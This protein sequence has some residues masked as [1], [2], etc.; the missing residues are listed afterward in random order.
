MTGSLL[1][2]AVQLKVSDV[3]T[4]EQRLVAV[5]RH[6]AD[7]AAAGADLVVLPEMWFQGYFA[8]DSYVD[9]AEPI[10]GPLATAL[11][12]L[13]AEHGVNLLAGSFAERADT[14]IHNTTL[15]FDREGARRAAYR[16][17]H[18]YGYG[19]KEQQILTPGTEVVTAEI[20]GI[21]FGIATCYDM[22][23]PELFRLLVDQGAEAFLVVAGWPFPRVGAW[24]TLAG[25][26]AT[27][28]Q[29]AMVAC[30]CAGSQ[31]GA[32][33]AGATVAFD[34]WGTCLGELDARPGVLRAEVDP[35]VIADARR[36]FPALADRRL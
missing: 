2:H 25:A 23:F 20:D 12:G 33:Y 27:E 31:L 16:K 13:A 29:A 34:P 5:R 24:R 4:P 7:S 17:I 22:R 9:R 3:D 35:Q 10:D 1:V 21:T 14:G 30:N 28:N 36:E 26:R 18:L 11:G 8:F 19:S 15:L 6:V 32:T